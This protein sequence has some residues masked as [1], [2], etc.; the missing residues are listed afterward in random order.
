MK[1][2][3][4]IFIVFILAFFLVACEKP[5]EDTDTKPKSI[6]IIG[7]ETVMEVGDEVTLTAKVTPSTV[8]QE[9]TW[10]TSDATI[11][12]VI[13]Q[14][15]KIK[16]K[17][18]GVAEVIATSK[19]DN[20]LSKKV[21]I[22]VNVPIVYDD[23]E[24]I[25]FT[26]TRAEV[27]INSFITVTAQVR[28]ISARQE[29]VWS[30][31]NEAVATVN[32]QGRVTGKS[33]GVVVI[34]ATAVADSSI[35][36]EFSVS[37]VKAEDVTETMPTEI[38]ITGENNVI[39]GNSIYLTADVFPQGA[40]GTVFWSSDDISIATVASSGRVTGLK[41]GSTFITA[42]SAKDTSVS[43]VFKFTVK[44]EPYNEPEPDLKS[45]QITI[46]GSEGHLDEHDPFLD[47]YIAADR[48]AKQKAWK[49]VEDLYNCKIVVEEFP[50][51]AP[52][53][54]MRVDW[55]NNTASTNS[56]TADIMVLTTQWISSLVNGGSV[57]DVAEYYE[58]YGRN[59]MPVAMKNASTLKSGLY[60]MI[61][62][63]P[64]SVYIDQGLFYN[65]NLVET[66]G[67]ESPAVIFNDGDWTYSKF[68]EYAKTAKQV[69]A[70]DQSVFSGKTSLYWMGMTNAAGVKL[71]DTNA[72]TVNFSNQYA[73]LAAS[74]LREAYL[75]VGWGTNAYDEGAESF[76]EGKS[77]FQ[78]GEYWFIRD[79][80]RWDKDMWGEGTT[81]FG[82][83]PY[84]RPDTV[85]KEDTRLNGGDGECYMMVTGVGDR[86]S[87]VT[88]AAVYRA[89]T[90]VIVKTAKYMEEDPT[91][92]EDVAMKRSAEYQ[93]DEAASL[94]AVTFFKRDKLIFDPIV[95]G[96]VVYSYISPFMDSIVFD[97]Q[98]YTEVMDTHYPYYLSEL[99]RLYG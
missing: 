40:S 45:Y 22:N 4:L 64:G 42:T 95:Y 10:S 72:L 12:E 68:V 41:A 85:T 55:V 77:I 63:S 27:G 5:E 16:A 18:A 50:T 13:D 67:L 26:S 9:V 2:F 79:P 86:P 88:E 44:P 1:K 82:Y 11:I 48:E 71:L 28:P 90:D 83:V 49:E 70:E 51:T 30:S 94:E 92:N 52:W 47:G 25:V 33:L 59:Q 7:V 66:L 89:W 21:A 61:R 81:K 57:V 36:A 34:T 91:Y 75:A 32:E 76:T 53:G 54:T 84:P 3:Y 74:A 78:S 29:I 46:L 96:I 60:S 62:S 35:K 43:K 8:S 15:G 6:E 58:L 69:M 38:V 37:V 14:T 23:P 39:E 65:V 20:R 97:G 93:L 17:G 80:S 98:D 56:H 31:N 73:R 24:S 99:Q 87:Y 19:V